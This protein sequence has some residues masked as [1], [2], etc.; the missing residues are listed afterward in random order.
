MLTSDDMEAVEVAL[1]IEKQTKPAQRNAQCYGA[2]VAELLQVP[3][4]AG[5]GNQNAT[6]GMEAAFP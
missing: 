1:N 6:C 2:G 5:L 3:A 4:S